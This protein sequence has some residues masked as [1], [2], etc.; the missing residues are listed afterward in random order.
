MLFTFFL[1]RVAI[2][3]VLYWWYASIV[4]V[5]VLLSS[6]LWAHL[7]VGGLWF[8]QLLWFGKM[9]K[10][11]IKLIADSRRKK[12]PETSQSKLD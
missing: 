10:G 7:A 9:L 6:P 1:C 8:P 4:G 5:G 12:K 3:P 11:S 2:F